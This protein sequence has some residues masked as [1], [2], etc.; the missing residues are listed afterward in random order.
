MEEEAK[1]NKVFEREFLHVFELAFKQMNPKVNWK[2]KSIATGDYNRY[3]RPIT[4]KI[5]FYKNYYRGKDYKVTDDDLGYMRKRN[6]LEDDDIEDDEEIKNVPTNES[7]LPFETGRYVV[8]NGETYIV[9]KPLSKPKI[10][11]IYNP[12]LQG[13]SAKLSVHEKNMKTLQQKG[14]IVLYGQ[15]PY[16]VTAKDEIIDLNTNRKVSWTRNDITRKRVVDLARKKNP[17][18]PPEQLGPDGK[19]PVKPEC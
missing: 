16:L 18:A 6:L 11:Q 5:P 9:T 3:D 12:L 10:W 19:P 14:A 1:D 2:S 8:Y 4:K 13:S 7:T 17:P 15:T